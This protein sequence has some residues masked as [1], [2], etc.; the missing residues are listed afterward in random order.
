MPSAVMSFGSLWSSVSCFDY[1][2]DSNVLSILF[3]SKVSDICFA[4]SYFCVE[5]I[6]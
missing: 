6:I 4:C 2:S 3:K 1:D 5:L